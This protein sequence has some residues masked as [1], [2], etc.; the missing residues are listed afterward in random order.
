M[1]QSTWRGVGDEL[2][3]ISIKF[4][5]NTQ[6]SAQYTHHVYDMLPHHSITYKDVV[7]T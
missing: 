5:L 3:Q 2:L 6:R 7:F 4:T 1:Y